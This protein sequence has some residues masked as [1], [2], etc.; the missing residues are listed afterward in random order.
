MAA[1]GNPE[2]VLLALRVLCGEV[3]RK[4]YCPLYYFYIKDFSGKSFLVNPEKLLGMRFIHRTKYIAE[5][6]ALASFRN[7]AHF[8]LTGDT[9]LPILHC[10]VSLDLIKQNT[11]LRIEG[12]YIHFLLE[13][14]P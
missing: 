2:K 1:K 14:L 5:Y 11:L 10:P 12:D 6:V 4:R 9:R 13:D 8:Q 7:Y 3:P